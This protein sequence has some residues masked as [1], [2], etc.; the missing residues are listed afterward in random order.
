M[1]SRISKVAVKI[2]PLRRD[3]LSARELLARVQTDQAVASNPDCEVIFELKQNCAP[4]VDIEFSDGQKE[5]FETHS[6]TID[7]LLNQIKEKSRVLV[8]QDVLKKAGLQGMKLSVDHAS[9]S[10]AGS[11]KQIPTF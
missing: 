1:L 9:K 2:S 11:A 10:F 5:T 6:L 7:Q 8:A 3:S 4:T